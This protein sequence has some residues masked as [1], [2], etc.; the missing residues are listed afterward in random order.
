[1][2]VAFVPQEATFLFERNIKLKF[3][4][5][6]FSQI[7]AMLRH[8]YFPKKNKVIDWF[9]SGLVCIFFGNCFL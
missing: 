1:M 9:I 3:K 6:I 4:E 8:L 7:P 2:Y 5:T